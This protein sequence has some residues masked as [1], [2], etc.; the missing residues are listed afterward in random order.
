[1][2][3]SVS[4]NHCILCNYSTI[5]QSGDLHWHISVYIV[6][7]YVQSFYHMCSFLKPPPQSRYGTIPSPQR[8]PSL[9]LTS[10]VHLLLPSIPNPW[11]FFMSIIL[12]L[13]E[14]YINRIT[15]DFWGLLFSLNILLLKSIQAAAYIKFIPL[16]SCIPWDGWTSFLNPSPYILVVPIWNYYK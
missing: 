10:H 13:Q 1:M 11:Q 7:L 8:F 3:S 15:Y 4:P 9:P 6:L 2:Y 14:C 12:W 16:L 5:S